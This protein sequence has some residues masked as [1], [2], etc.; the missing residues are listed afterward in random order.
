MHISYELESCYIRKDR[1]GF[2]PVIWLWWSHIAI[3]FHEVQFSWVSDMQHFAGSVFSYVYGYAIHACQ[4]VHV[5][6][7]AS[8]F[9]A[10]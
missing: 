1:V 2:T 3:D 6:Y 5:F 8:L 4:C 10:V 7:K 9:S